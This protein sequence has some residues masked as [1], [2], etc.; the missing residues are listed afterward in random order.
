[1]RR[2]RLALAGLGC[3]VLAVSIGFSAAASAPQSAQQAPLPDKT[4]QSKFEIQV[5]PSKPDVTASEETDSKDSGAAEKRL[6]P[7]KPPSGQTPSEAGAA[8]PPRSNKSSLPSL[9]DFRVGNRREGP[10][11][12]P[13]YDRLNEYG[14]LPSS[15]FQDGGTFLPI[16]QRVPEVFQ[17]LEP[18][19][20]IRQGQLLGS[21]LAPVILEFKILN[22][23]VR[24]GEEL[25]GVARL[26]AV[27][28]ARPF[29]ALFF[30]REAGRNKPA[31]YLN[32]EPSKK[33]P[34]LFLG[35]ALIG[36]YAVEGPYVIQD[37]VIGDENGHRKAYM[38]DFFPVLQ[39]PDGSPT[40]FT[41][42]ENPDS[43]ET[44]PRLKRVELAERRVKVEENIHFD[45]WMEDDK[46]GVSEAQA[47]WISPTR[48]QSIRADM[49][50]AQN[51]PGRFRSAFQIPE[52]YEGGA[53]ELL[54]VKVSDKATNEAHLF[55]VSVPILRN[56]KVMV[57]QNPA[58]VDKAP[59]RLLALQ[60]SHD[61]L[62]RDKELS[63]TMLVED[64]LSGVREA[65]ISFL[66]PYG[67]DFQ[68]VKLSNEAPNLNRRSAGKQLNVWR[69]SLKIRPT[70]EP[71]RWTVSRVNLS[72]NANN[73]ANYNAFREPM[74]RHLGVVFIDPRMKRNDRREPLNDHREIAA[75]TRALPSRRRSPTATRSSAPGRE[76]ASREA[77]PSGRRSLFDLGGWPGSA[78]STQQPEQMLCRA[79][80]FQQRVLQR[81]E[82][83]KQRLRICRDR[84]RR[85]APLVGGHCRAASQLLEMPLSM[86][87]RPHLAFNLGQ[88]VEMVDEEQLGKSLDVRR[89]G[90]L[91]VVHVR[92][93]G[94]PVR[95][96]GMPRSK[97]MQEACTSS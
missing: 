40:G 76:T 56:I 62:P 34:A 2:D 46:S 72:D 47:Y 90:R 60:L 14:V 79:L 69:G 81:L 68:R 45:I 84:L 41:V 54:S 75:T 74:L 77:D 61:E 1:M 36:T 15:A 53:W 24:P 64:D 67:A 42:A 10:G 28:K 27:N 50:Q 22:K 29:T 32:F 4:K 51:E 89:D 20:Q 87:Q 39:D 11:A 66:S 96:P 26:W 37:C 21:Q 13:P 85:L 88:H 48:D 97:V 80:E 16:E 82:L 5:K 57:D 33:D 25:R 35:R 18:R 83:P 93:L 30:H 73:Y 91:A 6:A 17:Y 52:N 94:A 12:I 65:H 19:E 95:E 58:K 55:P 59:P 49:V 86:R 31:I 8:D 70:Q 9:P 44:P 3:G 7:D 63:V 38:G 43:D 92:N 78:L 23:V 71:G